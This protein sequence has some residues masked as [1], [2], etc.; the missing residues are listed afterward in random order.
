MEDDT[1]HVQVKFRTKQQQYAVPDTPFSVPVEV[2]REKLSELVNGILQES[3]ESSGHVGHI[4]FDFLIDQ[5]F[6]HDSLK[7]H[8]EDKDLTSEVVLDIEYV[9]RQA[10]PRP[11]ESLEHDDWVSAVQGAGQFILSG[12]YDNTARLW[13][14]SGQAL[15]T[16]PGHSAPVKCV[17]WIH[18]DESQPVS[19]FVTGSH[20]QTALVWQWNRDTNEVDCCLSCSGHSASVDCVVVNSTG[21]LMCTGSW[22]RTLKLWSTAYTADGENSGDTDRPNKKKRREGSSIQQRV[23][24]LTLGGKSDGMDT[25]STPAGHTEAVSAVQWLN[26][27]TVVTASWDHTL[28]LWD[29]QQAKETALLQGTKAFLDVS[30]S[31]LSQTL[32]T[33]SADRHVRL[34]DPRSS[35]G[36]VVKCS[37]TSH[38]GWVVGVS[39]S[40]TREHLFLSGSYDTVLKLWDTRSPKAPLY[41]MN[42]HED[43]ILA[44]DWTVPQLMLSAGVDNRV[45]VFNYSPATSAT[46]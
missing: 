43:R 15:M 7:K 13:S 12:S 3:T 11:E 30:F 31:P 23:P 46:H 25:D 17:A 36:A 24:V 32:V 19:T 1:P 21:D 20:D 22:D 44:V 28:R 5:E 29:L 18:H 27:E 42:R 4:Q 37:F 38:T 14:S 6:L 39:W 40:P 45:N 26:T 8:L 33:A 2:N 9:E 41:D 16:I 10:A 34:Y 35:E